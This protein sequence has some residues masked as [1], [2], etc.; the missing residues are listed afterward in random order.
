[1]SKKFFTS[2]DINQNQTKNVVIEKVTSFPSNAK[3]G[4]FVYH[5]NKKSIYWCIDDTGD[6]TLQ[7]AWKKDNIEIHENIILTNGQT[8]FTLSYVP[9]TEY[10]IKVFVNGV[11]VK[12]TINNNQITITEY[13]AGTIDAGW[14]VDCYYYI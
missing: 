6:T 8:V 3:E 14:E 1:M 10:P 7:S 11:G 4:R 2:I 5:L 13:S 12:F 9:D